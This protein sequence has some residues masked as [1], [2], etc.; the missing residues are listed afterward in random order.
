MLPPIVTLL[1]IFA[2][3][4]RRPWGLIFTVDCATFAWAVACPDG[5]AAEAGDATPAA[6]RPAAAA[7]ST[8]TPGRDRCE[9]RMLVGFKS[10]SS[11]LGSKADPFR[12]E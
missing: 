8:S 5:S 6:S 12:K 11:G 10:V 1:M 9:R 2:L 3:P 4:P 7:D